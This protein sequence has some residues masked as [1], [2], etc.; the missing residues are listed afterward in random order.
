MRESTAI[1]TIQ[2]SFYVCRGDHCSVKYAV[3]SEAT[4]E[5]V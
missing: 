4:E 3:E 5:P 2:F 1:K